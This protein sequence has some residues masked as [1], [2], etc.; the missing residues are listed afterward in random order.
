MVRNTG[1]SGHS[2]NV[3][4]LCDFKTEILLSCGGEVKLQHHQMKRKLNTS[5]ISRDKRGV[6]YFPEIFHQRLF[7]LLNIN[8]HF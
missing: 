4:D 5:S 6:F 3:L 2:I 7:I 8:Y 1:Q